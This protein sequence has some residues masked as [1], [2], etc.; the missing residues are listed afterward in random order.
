MAISPETGDRLT[1]TLDRM[2]RTAR[3]VRPHAAAPL[4]GGLPSSALTLLSSIERDGE[5]CCSALAAGD[6]VDV[7]ITSRQLAVLQ[8]TGHVRRRP[9]PDDGRAGLFGSTPAGARPSPAAG[10]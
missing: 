10:G 3:H 7:S 9:D 8:R 2:G 4:R 5:Q 1:A 6:G